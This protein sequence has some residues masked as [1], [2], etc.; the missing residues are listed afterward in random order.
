MTSPSY[1]SI[2]KNNERNRTRGTAAEAEES[3]MPWSILTPR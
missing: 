3:G 1:I 2:I